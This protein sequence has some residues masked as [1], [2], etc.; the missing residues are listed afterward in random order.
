MFGSQPGITWV[1]YKTVFNKLKRFL[2]TKKENPTKQLKLRKKI[3]FRLFFLPWL[4][5]RKRDVIH[6]IQFPWFRSKHSERD[7][8]SAIFNKFIRSSLER[9]DAVSEMKDS[10]KF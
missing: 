1:Q 7:V 2:A 9:Y 10:V 5:N 3:F 8:L 4:L 6:T